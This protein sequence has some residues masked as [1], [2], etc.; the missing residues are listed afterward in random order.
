MT[1]DNAVSI[2]IAAST[3]AALAHI[4]P[5]NPAVPREYLAGI[6]L[7]P[8]GYAVATC[9]HVLMAV[10]CEP[11]RGEGVIIPRDTVESAV[12]AV[13]ARCRSGLLLPVSWQPVNPPAG[14]KRRQI[15]IATPGGQSNATEI[16]GT[17][18]DWRHICPLSLN[19]DPAVY[20][21]RLVERA[22]KAVA[23][24][25]AASRDV[26]VPMHIANSSGR[27]GVLTT[28]MADCL[29]LVVPMRW[30]PPEIAAADVAAFLAPTT[31][32]VEEAA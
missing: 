21:F 2:D 17:F 30:P 8:A 27:A 18:P 6:Y 7:D 22:Q 9:G 15:T 31:A 10:R 12:R 5:K 14:R 23:I 13:P 29:V 20:D 24:L 11:F 26:P 4:A 25:R 28:G 16:D 3:L 19:G 32:S 1:T